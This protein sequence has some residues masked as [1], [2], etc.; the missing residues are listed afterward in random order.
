MTW[1]VLFMMAVALAIIVILAPRSGDYSQLAWN[2]Q[3][4]AQAAVEDLPEDERDAER[5]RAYRAC[6]VRAF[7]G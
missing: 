3:Q 2:C 7:P 1:G 6:L 4:E 5:E